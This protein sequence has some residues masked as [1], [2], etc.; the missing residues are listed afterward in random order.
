MWAVG[1]L[2]GLVVVGVVELGYL[3]KLLARDV[4]LI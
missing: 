2:V 4:V 3:S 1:E